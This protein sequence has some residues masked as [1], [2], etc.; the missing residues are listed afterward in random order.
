M[1]D[2]IDAVNCV[3]CRIVDGTRSAH[4]VHRSALVVAFMDQF[5][6]PEDPGH[7]LVIPV[8][9]IENIYGIDDTLGAEIFRVH[10]R[11]ARAV[12]T[13]FDPDGISTWSSNGPGANQEVPHFHQHVYPRRTG[14]PFP[15][16]IKI[17]EVPVSDEILA[18]GAERI[19]EQLARL[20]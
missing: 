18:R 14:R 12:K 6:Q 2:R 8:G 20:P 11:I 7:V 13:A 15:Q 9:H 19:R 4:F 5:R 16:T 17:P 1:R 10:A 3:F